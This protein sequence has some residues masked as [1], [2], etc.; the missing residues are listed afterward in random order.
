MLSKLTTLVICLA[1]IVIVWMVGSMLGVDF[2]SRFRSQ[3]A[4]KETQE[5]LTLT[6]SDSLCLALEMW[7]G[8]EKGK[9]GQAVMRLIG[10]T[11]LN[12]R[13]GDKKKE[14]LCT[15][16]EQARLMLSNEHPA[17]SL[18]MA[19]IFAIRKI[20]VVQGEAYDTAGAATFAE[21][22]AVARELLAANDAG[23]L[24]ASILPDNLANYGCAT[25]FV[26]S[27]EGWL[28]TRIPGGF[29]IIRADLKAEGFVAKPLFEGFEFYCPP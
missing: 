18:R 15:I 6:E 9:A 12:Y 21:A 26:R 22:S 19:S 4:S 17:E 16:F 23:K 5:K 10:V 29:D 8:A 3:F 7:H 14:N 1:T 11:A 20:A 2:V 28:A 13:R 25:R 24:P 27:Y